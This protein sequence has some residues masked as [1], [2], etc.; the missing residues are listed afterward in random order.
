MNQARSYNL[1]CPI[2]GKSVVYHCHPHHRNNNPNKSQWI[3]NPTQEFDCFDLSYRKSW[4]KNDNAWGL[5]YSGQSIDYLGL[6]EDRNVN[7]FLAK[8]IKDQNQNYWHG[9]PADYQRNPQDIPDNDILEIWKYNNILSKPKIRK[10]MR[11]QPC[12]I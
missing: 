9:Y 3:I 2:T 6:G 5:H 8:F 12:N 7:L 10:I 11:G 4:L 1:N